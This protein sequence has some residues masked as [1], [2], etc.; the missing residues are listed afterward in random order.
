[1]YLQ[2][3]E[4]AAAECKFCELYKGQEKAV[5]ARGNPNSDVFICGMCPG[6][7]ENKIG[8][9]FV[10]TAG[11][12]L[13][14]ILIRVFSSPNIIYITN[15]VKCFVKP[16]IKLQEQWMNACLPYLIVQIS[17]VKPKVIILL[18]EDVS[19]YLLKT[20]ERIGQ[21]RNR[22]HTYMNIPTIC[23]YHPSYLARGGGVKHR[24][25]ERVVNDFKRSIYYLKI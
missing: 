3:L 18:G 2:S 6:P 19:Q 13:D 8:L 20:D 17:T 11:K 12:I 10:G 9:P 15:L 25:F 21:L 24:H 23:T 22:I 14:E 4:K 7:E 5:F 1:M 16:G